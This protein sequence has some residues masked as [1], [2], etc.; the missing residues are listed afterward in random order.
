MLSTQ[1]ESLTCAQAA[2]ARNHSKRQLHVSLC[3]GVC[4]GGLPGRVGGAHD[5]GGNAF[6]RPPRQALPEL[7]A[8]EGHEGV[9]QPGE[10]APHKLNSQELLL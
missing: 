10:H 3:S 6:L 5:G 4:P 8:D 1:S 2:R 7:L 9:Q